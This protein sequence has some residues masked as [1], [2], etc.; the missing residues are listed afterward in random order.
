MLITEN[1]LGYFNYESPE[2]LRVSHF[3]TQPVATC[4]KN[5]EDLIRRVYDKAKAKQKEPGLDATYACFAKIGH[6]E[7]PQVGMTIK[8][9]EP[10]YAL[11]KMVLPNESEEGLLYLRTK[12]LEFLDLICRV[13]IHKFDDSDMEGW[14]IVRKIEMVLDELFAGIG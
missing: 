6:I 4:L 14:D 1:I 8:E 7:S 3:W 13:A 9:F 10:L 11:S 2:T 5:N 12:F